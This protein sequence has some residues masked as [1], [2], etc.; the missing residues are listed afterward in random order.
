V[1][2]KAA[3]NGPHAAGLFGPSK[4]STKV[5]DPNLPR[6]AKASGIQ[7]THVKALAMMK[8]NIRFRVSDWLSFVIINSPL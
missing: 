4:N 7:N 2:E 6:M 3:T 1:R 8:Y 5:E